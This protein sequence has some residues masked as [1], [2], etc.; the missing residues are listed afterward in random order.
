MC[1]TKAE[2]AEAISDLRSYKTLNDE[3]ETKIKET[4][5]KIIEF[6]NETA[7]CATTDKKGNPI[8]QYI[9]ADYKATFSLQT[10]ENVNKEAVKKLLTPEQFAS[11]TTES[12]FGVLRVK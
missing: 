4:E 8:R 10:R 11:V 12:S 7:E 3:T 1:M 5:R 2:L 6:L 9:G